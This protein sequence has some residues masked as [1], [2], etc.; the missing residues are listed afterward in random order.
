MDGDTA[1][2]GHKGMREFMGKQT[3]EEKNA[4]HN[5]DAPHE[6][7]APIAVHGVELSNQRKDDEERDDQPAVM[8]AQFNAE[9]GAELDL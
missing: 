2:L 1:S 7:V 4:G 3:C 6:P 8:Q 5:C 9:D